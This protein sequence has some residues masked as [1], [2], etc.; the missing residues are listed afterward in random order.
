MLYVRKRDEA[1]FTPL[2]LVPPGIAGLLQAVRDKYGVE[3]D[4]VSALY[5]QCRKGVTVK[6][7]DD[8]LKHYCNEDT[9]II[10]IEQAVE[11]ASCCTITLV[12]LVDG[13][14]H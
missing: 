3:S 7:D 8:M 14:V 9:F 5:K 2:H 6:L 10:E 12:E 1:V 13:T 4:K 11:D